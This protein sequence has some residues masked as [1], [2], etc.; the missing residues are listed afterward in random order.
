MGT[1]PR[2]ELGLAQT[3]QAFRFDV[4]REAH[5]KAIADDVEATDDAALLERMGRPVLA[6]PGEPG[7]F[8]VTTRADLLWAE[9]ILTEG[10][11]SHLSSGSS[12]RS[13]G[14]GSIEVAHE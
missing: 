8:K 11:S 5:A 14:A 10:R 7:N 6:V 2:R 12:R 4:L 1:E 3:P 13:P 9:A